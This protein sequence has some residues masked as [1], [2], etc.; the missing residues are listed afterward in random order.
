MNY[1]GAFVDEWVC[2]KSVDSDGD[3]VTDD[4]DVCP[5]TLSGK[6]VYGDDGC[7]KSITSESVSSSVTVLRFTVFEF[8]LLVVGVPFG[9][10]YLDY[11]DTKNESK[12]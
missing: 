8:S 5:N 4:R 9:L 12:R 2:R 10:Y 11:S 3:G 1:S 7:A 6:E